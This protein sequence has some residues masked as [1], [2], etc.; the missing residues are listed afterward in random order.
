MGRSYFLLHSLKIIPTFLPMSKHIKTT[1]DRPYAKRRSLWWSPNVSHNLSETLIP[2]TTVH[3]FSN[4]FGRISNLD[5]CMLSHFLSDEILC[6]LYATFY[7][8]KFTSL[9]IRYWSIAQTVGTCG[10]SNW[11]SDHCCRVALAQVSRVL[12]TALSP[13]KTHFTNSCLGWSSCS[14]FCL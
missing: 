6:T 10:F 13:T 3:E 8:L 5:K 9:Y 11:D 4:T 2:S 12:P 14:I 7:L 1:S